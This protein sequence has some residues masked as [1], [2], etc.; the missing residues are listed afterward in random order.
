MAYKDGWDLDLGA[1]M[2]YIISPTRA[3][4]VKD[5]SFPHPLWKLAGGKVEP[6]DLSIVVT[7]GH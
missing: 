4:L 6:E 3:L 7:R 5:L 2:T 1:V